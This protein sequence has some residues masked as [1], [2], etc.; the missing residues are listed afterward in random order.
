MATLEEVENLVKNLPNGALFCNGKEIKELPNILWEDEV[1][2]ALIGG[3]YNNARGVLVASNKRLLFIDKGLMWGL[4]VEDFPYDKISSIQYSKGL[5]LGKITIFTYGN[6]ATIE[7][8]DKQYCAEFCE[9]VRARITKV[10]ISAINHDQN[11]PEY[12]KQEDDLID[13]LRRLGEL[14]T[15]GIL[16]D[17]E[18]SLAKQKLLQ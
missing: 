7:N 17:K 10:S 2:E 15:Q 1:V 9:K 8:T 5:L 16:T 12:I 11:I 6:N 4:K 3:K 14:K 18:F 13:K